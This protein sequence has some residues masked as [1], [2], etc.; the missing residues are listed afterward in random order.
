MLADGKM[1]SARTADGA[2]AEPGE[3]VTVLEIRGVRLIVEPVS[4]PEEAV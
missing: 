2:V 3:V 4:P 1:W